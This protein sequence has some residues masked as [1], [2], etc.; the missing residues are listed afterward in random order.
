MRSHLPRITVVAL[1]ATAAPVAAQQ[2]GLPTSQPP[3]LTIVREEVKHGRNAEHARH[4]AG[5]PAAFERAKSSA[6]YIALMSMTGPNEAWY[7]VP[8]QSHAAMAE[9]M[10]REDADDVLTAELRRLARADAELINS[11]RTI[12][13]RARPDLSLGDFP[14]VSKQRYYE[15]TTFRVRPGREALFDTAAKLYREAARKASPDASWR[16]YQV[17]AG[18]PGPTFLIFSSVGSFGQFDAMQAAD[19]KT[20]QGLSA[21]DL[22]TITRFSTD[23]LIT[24]ES[25]RFRLDPLQSYVP[26]ETRMADAA[27]WM[28]KQKTAAKP[29]LQQPAKQTP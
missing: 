2:S 8:Q 5:W 12:Q 13:A 3:I 26:R 29:R 23:G 25:N 16:I 15:I 18:M 1:L 27:F 28:P 10:K 6:Y 22:A 14:D 17:T 21:S 24:A 7:V 9:D 20:W 19:D 4:E 11:S